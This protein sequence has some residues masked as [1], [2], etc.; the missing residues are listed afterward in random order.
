MPAA[1]AEVSLDLL[2]ELQ[3]GGQQARVHLLREL[4]AQLPRHQAQRH[5]GVRKLGKVL[6]GHN[7]AKG[8]P[9]DRDVKLLRHIKLENLAKGITLDNTADKLL[10]HQGKHI[11]YPE[12]TLLLSAAGIGDDSNAIDVTRES[13]ERVGRHDRHVADRHLEC[14]DVGIQKFLS[15]C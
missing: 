2:V 6:E 11:P 9:R 10:I 1:G 4:K 14:A 15:R 5:I 13:H 12:L 8:P 3:R 7:V